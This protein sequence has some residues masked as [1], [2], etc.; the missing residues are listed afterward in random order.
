MAPFSIPDGLNFTTMKYLLFP[1]HIAYMAAIYIPL[2]LLAIFGLY[3]MIKDSIKAKEM[4]DNV[5]LYIMGLFVIFIFP[6]TQKFVSP[7]YIYM[8]YIFLYFMI[9]YGLA[10]LLEKR[11]AL[12]IRPKIFPLIAILLLL[13]I[14]FWHYNHPYIALF[15]K[16]AVSAQNTGDF[17]ASNLPAE[18]GIMA[19]PGYG[20][21]LIYLTGNRIIGLPPQPETLAEMIRYY[22][23]SYIVFG[24]RY[25]WD[26]Y[27]V[28]TKSVEFVRNNP[29]KF[30]LVASIQE[31]Y[32]GFYDEEDLAGT[33]E[34]YIYKVTI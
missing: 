15:N 31:D 22:N 9:G 1:R 8:S 34:V 17:I 4:H 10:A 14:P 12:Q 7:R 19:Q 23:I 5:N 26:A 2:A 33:D 3:M 6:I 21:K 29:D 20:V 13:L 11:V 27:Y 32:G 28:S 30:E 18:A 24:R 16:K 25:T